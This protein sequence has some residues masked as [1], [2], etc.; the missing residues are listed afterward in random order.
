MTLYYLPQT[1]LAVWHFLI[2][3]SAAVLL[4]FVA[5]G[6]L[7]LSPAAALAETVQAGPATHSE[8]LPYIEVVICLAL[9]L[10]LLCRSSGRRAEMNLEELDED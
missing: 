7:A 10:I 9:G 6:Y 3:R 1:I 2:R 5:G 8:T 4:G